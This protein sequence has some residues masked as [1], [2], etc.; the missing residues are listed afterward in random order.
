MPTEQ[1]DNVTTQ[2]RETGQTRLTRIIAIRY[3]KEKGRFPDYPTGFW[4][5]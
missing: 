1:A 3:I 5:R 4:G 2:R